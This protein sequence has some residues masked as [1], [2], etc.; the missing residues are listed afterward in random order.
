M[1]PPLPDWAPPFASAV[2]LNCVLCE[3]TRIEPPFPDALAEASS[4]LFAST[5]T[6]CA[7]PLP[8]VILPPPCVPVALKVA[9]ARLTE[10]PLTEIDPPCEPDTD[11]DPLTVTP[12]SPPSR[13][14]SPPL[15]VALEAS[16]TP[17][18]LMTLSTIL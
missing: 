7:A 9:P 12:P 5:V 11:T 3:S 13:M 4:V 17:V 6:D 16:I 18:L 14:T 15:T 2:P 8:T 10:L 1:L